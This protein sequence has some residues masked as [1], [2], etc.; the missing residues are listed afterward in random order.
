MYQVILLGSG[1]T[2][3]LAKFSFYALVA[4]VAIGAILIPFWG[5]L[6]LL[7]TLLLNQWPDYIALLMYARKVNQVRL[8]ILGI[9]RVHCASGLAAIP[10][11][12][13]VI[14]PLD[15]IA[16][17]SLSAAAMLVACVFALA[18]L[19]AVDAGGLVVSEN[20]MSGPPYVNALTHPMVGIISRL[21]QAQ[22]GSL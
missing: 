2:I 11:L 6:G 18:K 13:V 15:P 22:R 9:M 21:V 1:N 16:Q 17:I 12:L 20:S 8:P 3:Y 4:G 5:V 14:S 10:A 7:A 19:K